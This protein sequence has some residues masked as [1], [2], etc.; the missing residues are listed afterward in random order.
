M[1]G[2]HPHFQT[3]MG[4]AGAPHCH[5]DELRG[6]TVEERAAIHTPPGVCYKGVRPRNPNC[7]SRVTEARHV[8]RLC[9]SLRRGDY[10]LITIEGRVSYFGAMHNFRFGLMLFHIA[11]DPQWTLLQVHW[12]KGP[13]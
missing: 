6:L 11:R 10:P 2:T 1:G 5:P 7:S 8:R 9:G 3:A 4:P 12:G 13:Y